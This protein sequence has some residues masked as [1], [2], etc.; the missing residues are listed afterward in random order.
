MFGQ[1][2]CARDG[3]KCMDTNMTKKQDAKK[4]ILERIRQCKSCIDTLGSKDVQ[5][6]NPEKMKVNLE[7]DL[8]GYERELTLLNLVC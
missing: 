2:E 3:Q 7:K 8:Q 1:E 6:T 4:F 5:I